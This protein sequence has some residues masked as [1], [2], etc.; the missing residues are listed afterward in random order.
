M[1]GCFQLGA[2]GD[3]RLQLDASWY[4][5]GP[6]SRLLCSISS[7][8]PPKN[9][10]R[11]LLSGESPA[12]GTEVSNL[13]NRLSSV[14]RSVWWCPTMDPLCG[15]VNSGILESFPLL[16]CTKDGNVTEPSQAQERSLWVALRN[17]HAKSATDMLAMGCL[18]SGA[19]GALGT[20]QRSRSQC[21]KYIRLE[22]QQ[23]TIAI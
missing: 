19:T 2:L 6:S 7:A 11:K 22:T 1:L 21:K 3:N 4:P 15:L 20:A 8:D 23:S 17:L 5:P 12:L 9:A 10:G 13:D 14:L 18:P 16:P